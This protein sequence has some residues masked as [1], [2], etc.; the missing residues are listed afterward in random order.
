M[1]EVA[2]IIKDGYTKLL[3]EMETQPVIPAD[4]E[5]KS[6][7][8]V[9]MQHSLFFSLYCQEAIVYAYKRGYEEGTIQ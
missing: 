1:K 4:V 7:W 8:V 5:E 9:A 6:S 3:T 2:E